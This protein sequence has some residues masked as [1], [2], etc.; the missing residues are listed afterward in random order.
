MAA[1]GKKVSLVSENEWWIVWGIIFAACPCHKGGNKLFKKATVQR[2]APSVNFGKHGM[3]VI[4]SWHR[5]KTIKELLSF[6]FYDHTCPE[7][8][9]YPV[10]LLVDGFNDNRREKLAT[11][12]KIVL[13]ESMSPFQP[14]TTKTSKLPNLSFIFWKPKPLGVENKVSIFW[15]VV[16]VLIFRIVFSPVLTERR[17]S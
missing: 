2:L 13:D 15:L 7:D 6:A 17:L 1:K 14:R 12:V 4:I 9:Y 3:D 16:A 8:P 11:A 10:K 5:F